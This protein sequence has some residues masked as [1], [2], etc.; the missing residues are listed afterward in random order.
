MG[1]GWKFRIDDVGNPSGPVRIGEAALG[2]FAMGVDVVG[3]TCVV[4]TDGSG[5]AV[6]KDAGPGPVPAGNNK[7]VLRLF[8]VR[9]RARSPTLLRGRTAS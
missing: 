9:V 4:A 6:F 7:T 8:N 2:D 5:L 1:A 3:T